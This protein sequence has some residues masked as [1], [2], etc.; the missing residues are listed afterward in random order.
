MSKLTPFV[1]KTKKFIET[2]SYLG[3]GIQLALNSGFVEIYSI[4]LCQN[5]HNHCKSRFANNLN[6]H[7]FYGDSSHQL[8]VVLDNFADEN[9]TFWLDGH[10]SG[11]GTAKGD[12]ECPLV[13]ELNCILS[14]SSTVHD[15][16]YID[17]MR[18]YKQLDESIN[19]NSILQLVKKH[20]KDFH[21]QYESSK[22][23]PNDILIIE[24]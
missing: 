2:G 7:L 20:K 24:Y 15:V 3:D 18:I 8:K 17:D 9:C 19:E 6:V 14:R 12:K 21:F 5:L 4:E 13:E 16:I 22:F 10:Y 1:N 23:D 11:D